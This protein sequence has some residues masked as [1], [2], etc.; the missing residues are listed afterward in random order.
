MQP[1]WDGTEWRERRRRRRKDNEKKREEIFLFES[2]KTSRDEH[3]H[4]AYDADRVLELLH[5][6][7]HS[8][9]S[10]AHHA[11]LSFTM[12]LFFSFFLVFLIIRT[13]FSRR[14]R[15]RPGLRSRPTTTLVSSL[16][17]LVSAHVVPVV[18]QGS[19]GAGAAASC[20]TNDEWP[21]LH[22]GG[23]DQQRQNWAER[24]TRSL[25][26]GHDPSGRRS[27]EKF[28]PRLQNVI[29]RDKNL[30]KVWMQPRP[31]EFVPFTFPDAL[32][33]RVSKGEEEEEEEEEN[34]R[35]L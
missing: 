14:R 34:R 1:I 29:P 3:P 20:S 23:R 33:V 24:E 18:S 12:T 13:P 32:H 17:W 31:T 9:R 21:D 8:S 27:W 10:A 11:P 19:A 7:R 5:V 30:R 35:R 25:C 4:C 26:K 22:T 2:L 15:R 16:D 28:P 6:D